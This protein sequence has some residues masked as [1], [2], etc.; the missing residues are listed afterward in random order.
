MRLLVVTPVN[1]DYFNAEI[2]A[3]VKEVVAPDTRIDVKNINQGTSCIQ[4][5]VDL[6]VN[7]PHVIELIGKE[8][9]NYDGVFVTD[10]DMCGVEQSR[11][12]V[13]IPVIGGFRASAYTAMML[14]Q[15]YA[16][17]TIRGTH[18]LQNEHVRA[19]GIQGNLA[20][21]SAL[22][23]GVYDLDNKER[24]FDL[25]VSHALRAIKSNG[26]ES[27]IFGC[28]GFVGYAEPLSRVLSEELSCYIPVIDPNHCAIKYLELLVLNKLRQ[29]QISYPKVNGIS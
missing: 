29:S 3:S 12:L 11:E 5:R 10:M 19:F 23:L 8:A 13:D 20:T 14:S 18:D 25:L 6:A 27:I 17:L 28:T 9:K 16:I 15:K 1:T 21:I 7:A 22:D 24:V 26:A 4:S 2:A